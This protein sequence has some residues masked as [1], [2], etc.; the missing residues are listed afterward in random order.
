MGQTCNK[1]PDLSVLNYPNCTRPK[2]IL[3]ISVAHPVEILGATTL[4]RNQA[5]IPNHAANKRFSEKNHKYLQIAN[6][7]NFEFLPFIVETTGRMHLMAVKFF[8]ET[9][10]YMADTQSHSDVMKAASSLYWSTRISCCIQ[11]SIA[12]SILSRSRSI[13]GNLTREIAVE[14]A[15]EFGTVLRMDTFS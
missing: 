9:I 14:Y 7:N 10:Q 1:R 12:R 11:K 3:D 8:D 13:D 2:L 15:R 4:S 6:Q 5:I